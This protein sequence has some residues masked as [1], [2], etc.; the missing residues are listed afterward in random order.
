MT[1]STF[2]SALLLQATITLS[3]AQT[4]IQHHLRGNALFDKG[5]YGRTCITLCLGI[6]FS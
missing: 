6:Y 2:F 4:D 3:F 1:R 5:K